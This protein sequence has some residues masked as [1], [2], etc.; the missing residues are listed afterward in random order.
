M[1]NG[2]R[3]Y[4]ATVGASMHEGRPFDAVDQAPKLPVA[5]INEPFADRR[6]RGRSP[7]GQRF[8]FGATGDEGYCTRLSVS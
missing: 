5:I 1:R 3:D 6:F 4:F 8:K 2:S 7:L